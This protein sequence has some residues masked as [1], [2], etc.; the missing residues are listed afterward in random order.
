MKWRK[1]RNKNARLNGTKEER[2]K[3]AIRRTSIG[4]TEIEATEKTRNLM[5]KG[6]ESDDTTIKN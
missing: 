2:K 4:I 6:E 1:W 5:D 3:V